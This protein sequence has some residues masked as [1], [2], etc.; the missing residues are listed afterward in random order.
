M[1]EKFI[2]NSNVK[3]NSNN[4][5]CF[6]DIETVIENNIHK[7]VVISI[8]HEKNMKSFII[9][10]DLNHFFDYI[11]LNFEKPIIYFH[12]FGRFDSI[13]LLKNLITEQNY[14]IT[15]IIERNNVIYQIQINNIIFRD[16]KLMIPL[17]LQNIGKTFCTINN[18][19]DFEYSDISEIYKSNPKLVI[20]QCEN[21]CLVL[22]EGFLKFR[23]EIKNQFNISIENHLT[24]PSLALKLFK[25]NYYDVKKTPISKNSYDYDE[26]IRESYYGGIADVY[27]PYLENGYCYDVNS[28]YP[29]IMMINKF[30]VGMPKFVNPDE[31]DINN[32]IGFIKCHVLNDNSDNTLLP[33]RDPIKGLICPAGRWTGVYYYKE[34]LKAIELGYHIEIIKGVQ[35]EK[36]DYIFSNFVND[37]YN[38]RIKNKNNSKNI[39]CKLLMNSLY[40]RFGMKIFVENTKF[41][42]YKELMKMKE[43]YTLINCHPLIESENAEDSLYIVTLRRNPVNNKERYN[44]SVDTETAVQIASAITSYARIYIYPFKNLK[45]NAC[46]YS[47]TD[48]LFLE[49]ELDK[50]H[51]G[52][53]LGK[54]K[55]E[56]KVKKGYFLAPKIYQI[57]FFNNESKNVF[58]GLKKDEFKDYILENTFDKIIYKNP[59]ISVTRK[60][61]FVVNFIKLIVE[62]KTTQINFKFPFRKRERRRQRLCQEDR[63]KGKEN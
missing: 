40:G 43:N 26:F 11:Q 42:K 55:L 32:F 46:Y 1:K 7:A 25:N 14:K 54:F 28:L 29:Y 16:S 23:S 51:V 41:I 13:F 5:L 49:K 30:P 37:L 34:V 17:S 4:E 57:K 62:R 48:S 12:N 24:I 8:L 61:N 38:L 18:K 9:Q 31:I 27:K 58:K 50:I 39:I 22:Q 15:K 10:K 36:E 59:K 3:K 6:A 56:Y 2:V 19:K 52:E 20:E 53:E 60:S 35:Y 44:L 21:D 45:N 33:Y 47:D 63:E